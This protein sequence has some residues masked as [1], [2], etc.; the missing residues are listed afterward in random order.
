MMNEAFKAKY[1]GASVLIAGFGRSG[2]AAFAALAGVAGLIAVYDAKAPEKAVPVAAGASKVGWYFGGALPLADATFDFVV[3][4]PGVPPET[5][6]VQSAMEAGAALTGD[7]ELAID[8]GANKT[9]AITGTNGK[10]TTTAL[11]GELWKNAGRDCEVTGNIGTPVTEAVLGAPEGREF[12]IEA[13]SFQLEAIRTGGFRPYIAAFLNL[14]PDH[15]DR[16]HTMESYG[17]AKA[18]L[19]MNQGAGDFLVLNAD[20]AGLMSLAERVHSDGPGPR[21]LLFS[22]LARVEDGAFAKA[23]SVYIA[24]KGE[25]R[26]LME[27][28][29]ILIPGSHNLENALAAVAMAVCGGIPDEIIADTLRRFRGVPHRMELIDVIGG[30]RFVNDSKGTNTDASQK[31]VDAVE[32]DIVLIAGGYDKQADFTEFIRSFGGKVKH[33]ALLGETAERFAETA[34][35]NGFMDYTIVRDMG[36]AVRLGYRLARPGATVLLSPASASWDQYDN[37]EQRGD[38]FRALVGKLKEGSHA[39]HE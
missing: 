21:K 28:A 2:R 1:G 31:A 38:H 20:D 5:A 27:A 10:T 17:A 11:A 37:F 26:Y 4:S 16:Y 23:G 33:L 13:S 19:F 6:V 25:A 32:G 30:V 9:V 22:R 24:Q 12:I 36:E 14:T 15:L 18:R 39:A 29:D 8:L 7:L 35:A 34:A 3:L